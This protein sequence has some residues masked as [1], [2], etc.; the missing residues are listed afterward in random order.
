MALPSRR[1]GWRETRERG[2]RFRL[3]EQL[4]GF[5]FSLAA[6]TASSAPVGHGWE[7]LGMRGEGSRIRDQESGRRDLG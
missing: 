1:G 5:S 4:Q 2:G 6:P 7:R 3:Q